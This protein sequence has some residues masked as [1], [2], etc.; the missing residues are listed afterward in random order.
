VSLALMLPLGLLAFGAILVPLLI[1]LIRRHE[2]T[3]IDF[4]ALRW[5]RTSIQP[6]RRLRFDELGLLFLR[7]LLIALIALLLA[8]PVL[9]GEWRDPR[10]WV[11]VSADV[12]LDAARRNVGDID[13]EWRWLAPG[14]PALDQ[15][16]LESTRNISSLL[17]EFDATRGVADR[18]TVVVPEILDGLDAERLQL[19]HEV[20]WRIERS[21]AT[22]AAPS[23]SAP[24]RV[25]LR[26]GP[27]PVAGESF[28][29]AAV[30][31]WQN[32]EPGHWE[33]EESTTDAP[34]DA[35]TDWLIWLGGELP[36]EV[37][38]WVRAGGHA[39]TVDAAGDP[40]PGVVVWRDAQGMPLA[41]DETLGAGHRIRLLRSLEADAFPDLL[42]AGFAARIR[43]LLL[44]RPAAPASAWA[45]SVQPT[46]N[47][48]LPVEVRTPLFPLLAIAIALVFLFERVLATRGRSPP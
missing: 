21:R 46:R 29:R 17:R 15:V 20:D 38:A 1:H 23:P 13:A 45:G 18:V 14:F 24:R 30:N 25:S 44:G 11:V 28:L 32:S 40:L 22:A 41:R 48:E 34:L 2:Q 47:A 42:D 37:L 10:H 43:Q 16:S 35:Q 12:D 39:L 6:R 19:A 33:I 3:A 27:T 26:R 8:T 31:A 36:V 7:L 5:L 9:T 4:P